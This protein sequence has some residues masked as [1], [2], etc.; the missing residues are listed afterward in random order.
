MPGGVTT[1]VDS[2]WTL[3]G[4]ES[5]VAQREWRVEP[6]SCSVTK[7]RIRCHLLLLVSR[8]GTFTMEQSAWWKQLEVYNYFTNNHAS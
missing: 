7:H 6:L 5:L 4:G 2:K 8:S 1:E 3:A